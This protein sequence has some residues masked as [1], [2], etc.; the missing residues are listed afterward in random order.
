MTITPWLVNW[1]ARPHFAATYCSLILRIH[2]R[3]YYMIL[4][5]FVPKHQKDFSHLFHIIIFFFLKP[6]VRISQ[7]FFSRLFPSPFTD[8]SRVVHLLPY[9]L[10]GAFPGPILSHSAAFVTILSPGK[11]AHLPIHAMCQELLW[12]L[13]SPHKRK[14]KLPLSTQIFIESRYMNKLEFTRF[15]ANTKQTAISL[16]PTS[17][18]LSISGVTVLVSVDDTASMDIKAMSMPKLFTAAS[19]LI[20]CHLAVHHNIFCAIFI[21]RTEI[22]RHLLHGSTGTL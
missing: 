18:E 22:R 3:R 2:L 12:L 4:C 8:F 14:G 11:N 17:L 21:R 5:W 6:P 16:L 10:Y 13:Y 20:N 7:I 15:H 19:Q 1:E 9:T